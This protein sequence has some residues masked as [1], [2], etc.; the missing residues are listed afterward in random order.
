MTTGKKENKNLLVSYIAPW[1][2]P[3]VLPGAEDA[4]AA[5]AHVPSAPERLPLLAA[6]V[7][8]DPAAAR[9]HQGGIDARPAW[10][11]GEHPQALAPH[12]PDRHEARESKLESEHQLAACLDV[13]KQSHRIGQTAMKHV[14]RN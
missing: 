13:R 11:P 2:A 1:R 5:G 3:Q 10:L 8:N 4:G 14:S 7:R 6:D 12:R 9:E